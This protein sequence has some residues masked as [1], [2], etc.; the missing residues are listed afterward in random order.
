MNPEQLGQKLAE[1]LR[2]WGLLPA[3]PVLCPIPVR[4]SHPRRSRSRR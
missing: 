4:P 2:R 1:L 3:K